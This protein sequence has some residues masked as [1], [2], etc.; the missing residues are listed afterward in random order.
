MSAPP[1]LTAYTFIPAAVG[2]RN[3][4]DNWLRVNAD[5]SINVNTSGSSASS[6][7]IIRDGTTASRT[8]VVNADG[9]INLS[10]AAQDDLDAIA[11]ATA[12]VADWDQT[13][14]GAV[15]VIVGQAG[16]AGGTGT[17]GAT[18]PR[19]TLATNVGLPA[20]ANHLGSV[21]ASSVPSPTATSLI[22]SSAATT[23]PTV[24][25][26]S[27]GRIFGAQGL[28]AA[29][30]SRFLKI[31]D[32]A[33]TPSESDTPVKTLAMPAGAGFAYDW[34][35]GYVMAAGISFRMTVG[36]SNSDTISV[37]AADVLAFNLDYT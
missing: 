17:D 2:D 25:K 6:E 11:V 10:Q 5:G 29:S 21:S 3:Q 1:G 18:V 13:G 34:A 20:G 19:V 31:Y 37:S 24:A 8:L 14:R 28:C 23:N 9:S 32:K 22:P 4:P 33:T 35:G 7:V 16:I 12:T 27:A 30:T 15:N 26:A 36:V